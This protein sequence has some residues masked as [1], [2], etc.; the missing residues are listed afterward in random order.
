[1]IPNLEHGLR[2]FLP[3]AELERILAEKPP[4]ETD[5]SDQK[6]K[7]RTEQYSRRHRTEG[8]GEPEPQHGER[9]EQFGLDHVQNEDTDRSGDEP[10]HLLELSREQNDEDG[11]HAGVPGLVLRD[12]AYSA[13]SFFRLV[14]RNAFNGNG[15]FRFEAFG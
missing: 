7:D 14:H 15:K 9:L 5:G 13:R 10:G 4:D 6:E 12:R 11:S 3:F 1:V 8:M 2:A